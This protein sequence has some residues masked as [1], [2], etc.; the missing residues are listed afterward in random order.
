[1]PGQMVKEISHLFTGI[2]FISITAICWIPELFL[3][4]SLDSSLS[5]Y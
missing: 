2:V 1:M 4:G 3:R 5:R